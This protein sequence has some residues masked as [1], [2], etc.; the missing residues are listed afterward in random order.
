[1]QIPQGAS[2][3]DGLCCQPVVAP[4]VVLDVTLDED[5]TPTKANQVA[6]SMAGTINQRAGE[7]ARNL[8]VTGECGVRAR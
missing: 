3:S 5:C 8:A 7:Q 6:N 1:M 4:Q 2:A